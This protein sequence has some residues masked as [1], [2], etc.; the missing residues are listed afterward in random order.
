MK[1]PGAKEKKTINEGKVNKKM[2]EVSYTDIT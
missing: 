2:T 1:N